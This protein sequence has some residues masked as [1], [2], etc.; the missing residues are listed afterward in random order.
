MNIFLHT[1]LQPLSHLFEPVQTVE[2]VDGGARVLVTQTNKREFVELRARAVMH[3]GISEQLRALTDGFHSLVAPDM[4][5]DLSVSDLHTALCGEADISVS[6][7]RKHTQ[8]D[9]SLAAHKDLVTDFWN[10]L[11]EA[12]NLTRSNILFFA[13]GSASPPPGGF[14]NLRPNCFRLC[15]E[16][17]MPVGALPRAHACF[18]TLVLPTDVTGYEDL[19]WR[20]LTAARECEGYGLL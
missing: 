18:C 5:R 14:C 11:G 15:T 1:T 10:V 8:V 13:T 6:D 12:D 9:E 20:V 4:L 3:H 17:H 2:L 7:W 19:R 16:Q